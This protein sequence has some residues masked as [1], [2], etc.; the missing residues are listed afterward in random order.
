MR[1]R[2]ERRGRIASQPRSVDDPLNLGLALR[3]G[4]VEPTLSLP[5]EVSPPLVLAPVG[6]MK[7]S[8]IRPRNRP[9]FD[10]E[11]EEFGVPTFPAKPANA[12]QRSS[13]MQPLSPDEIPKISAGPKLITFGSVSAYS[14]SKRV[15]GVTNGL[16]RHIVV[17]LLT[18]AHDELKDSMQSTQVIPPGAT[19]GFPI[20]LRVSHMQTIS[21]TV[22]YTIN[23]AS[24]FSFSVAAEVVPVSLDISTTMLGFA[25]DMHNAEN[26]VE[27]T[28]IIRNPGAQ[29]A[30]YT[31]E[32]KSGTTF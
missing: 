20:I 15:F 4:L 11:E 25:F 31:W 18:D 5:T 9:A 1:H 29:P 26:F 10:R 12:S 17:S 22:N 19:A 16:A 8:L 6:K 2:V 23:A 24:L 28:L 3:S 27:E 14:S 7:Q 13:I 21:K 30:E 32:G